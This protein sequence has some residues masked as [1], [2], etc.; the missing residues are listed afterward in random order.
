[1]RVIWAIASGS[2]SFIKEEGQNPTGSFKA[3]G[4]SAAE[5]GEGSRRRDDRVAH[6]RQCGRR[7]SR[8]RRT[9]GA[10]LCGR[11]ALGHA[12][13]HRPGDAG[14]RCRLN[15]STGSS[16]AAGRRIAEQAARNGW[17]EV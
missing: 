9:G 8:I 2:K 6:R 12:D 14:V 13:R 17:A 15:S 11:N 3:R 7:R 4:L 5:H 10:A 1:M 16:L